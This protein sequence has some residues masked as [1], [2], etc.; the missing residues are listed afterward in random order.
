MSTF[1][2]VDIYSMSIFAGIYSSFI[3]GLSTGSSLISPSQVMTSSQ[4]QTHPSFSLPS[5]LILIHV[6][7]EVRPRGSTLSPLFRKAKD[8]KDVLGPERTFNVKALTLQE[9]DAL[10]SWILMSSK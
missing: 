2:N 6:A 4:L 7:S 10:N 9:S 3:Y 8:A 5:T 1:N